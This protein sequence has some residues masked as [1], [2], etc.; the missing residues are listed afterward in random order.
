VYMSESKLAP[1]QL[2]S[3]QA[4]IGMLVGEEKWP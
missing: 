3:A 1:A 2:A 4:E